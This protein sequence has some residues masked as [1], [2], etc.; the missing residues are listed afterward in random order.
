M[1]DLRALLVPILAGVL[2]LSSGPAQA[3]TN[4]EPDGT[5]HPYVGLVVFYLGDTPSHRCS[6]TLLSATVLLTAGH[7]TFDTTSAQVWSD[8]AVQRGNWAGGPCASSTGF[9]CTG[10]TRGTPFT[11]LGF[12]NFATFPNT[13]DIGI[14]VLDKRVR[15]S[16]YGTLSSIGFLD[17]LATARGTKSV[18]FTVV[19]YGLQE[20]V[21]NF[22]ADLER[23]KASSQLVELSSALTDGFN[24]HTSSS[25]GNGTGDGTTEPG[26]TCFGDSGGPVFYGNSNVIVA[27]TSFG[28]NANCVGADYAYRTDLASSQ[29]FINS[30]LN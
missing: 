27:V 13:S 17:G 22:Q 5:D 28:L 18:T 4:G 3:I 10:G 29:A 8:P 23:W 20:I 16:T 25:P 30:F 21:P 14:V 1:H 7:C 6:G 11:H 9:P 24:L 19:G 12:D 15:S 26:G 2:L